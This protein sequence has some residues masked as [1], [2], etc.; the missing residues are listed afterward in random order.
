M[1]TELNTL[2][3]LMDNIRHLKRRSEFLDI[4]LRYWDRD[5]M[6]IVIPE[7]WD[8]SVKNLP[9]DKQKSLPKSPRHSVLKAM[10]QLLGSEDYE[11]LIPYDQSIIYQTFKQ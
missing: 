10:I 7:Q 9:D 4:L 6:T 3:G 11:R 5:K 1:F 2:D 8:K